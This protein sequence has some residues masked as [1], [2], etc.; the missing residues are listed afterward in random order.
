MLN[1]SRARVLELFGAL[2]SVMVIE[3][4]DGAI[5]DVAVLRFS[6][7]T[8]REWMACSGMEVGLV[9]TM[10]LVETLVGNPDDSDVAKVERVAK[11]IVVGLAS[12]EVVTVSGVVIF[13]GSNPTGLLSPSG[14][15]FSDVFVRLKETGVDRVDT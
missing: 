15:R 11:T 13:M 6:V 4:V 5:C 8:N 1:P 2:L 7:V 3:D 9:D 14:L 12:S 10:T